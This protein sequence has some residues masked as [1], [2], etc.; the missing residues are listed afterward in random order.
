MCTHPKTFAPSAAL[1][2]CV[3]CERCRVRLC[4]PRLLGLMPNLLLGTSCT[5]AIANQL[6]LD[7]LVL[8]WPSHSQAIHVALAHC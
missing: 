5:A 7:P 1:W 3:A 6:T 4:S 2:L 8:Y